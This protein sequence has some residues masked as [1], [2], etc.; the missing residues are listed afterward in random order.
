MSAA[1]FLLV[2][3]V[4][5]AGVTE[6]QS[7]YGVSVSEMDLR[8]HVASQEMQECVATLTLTLALTLILTVILTALFLAHLRIPRPPRNLPRLRDLTTR[9]SPI[10]LPVILCRRTHHHYRQPV[11]ICHHSLL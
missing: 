8:A 11:L 10:N 4:D 2:D 1:G 6:R 3:G 9:S 7:V 5:A